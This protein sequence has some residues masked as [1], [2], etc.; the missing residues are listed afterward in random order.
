[1]LTKRIV[2]FSLLTIFLIGCQNQA[3]KKA[4]VPEN[5]QQDKFLSFLKANCAGYENQKNDIQ[6]GEFLKQFEKDFVSFSDSLGILTNWKG[7]LKRIKTF[8][9]TTNNVTEVE[10]EIEINLASYQNLT[11]VSQRF[12]SNKNIDSNLTYRQ[13]K[14][15]TNGSTVYFD[16]FLAKD[17]DNKI[18]YAL[19]LS[20]DKSDKICS[21]D[22][23]FYLISVAKEKLKFTD[24]DIFKI[25]NS[26]QLEIWKAMDD[27]VNGRI[28]KAQLQSKL[29]GFKKQIDSVSSKFSPEEKAYF[30]SSTDCLSLQFNSK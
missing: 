22:I 12:F 23:K 18:D 9:W 24:S 4:D 28:N 20:L 3:E 2:F 17:K 30:Q 27:A 11:F 21:P 8:D 10:V 19:S 16:G 1:M 26:V 13:L 14:N 7:K 29:N 5:L 6:R 25:A 15:L